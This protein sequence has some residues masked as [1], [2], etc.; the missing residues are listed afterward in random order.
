M[1]VVQLPTLHKYHSTYKS[2]SYSFIQT[3]V[4]YYKEKGVDLP[5]ISRCSGSLAISHLPYN[6]AAL[7]DVMVTVRSLRSPYVNCL[8]T[9][10]QAG[11]PSTRGSVLA[12]AS[13]SL[14]RNAVGPTKSLTPP[15][16]YGQGSLLALCLAIMM[17]VLRAFS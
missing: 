7:A 3:G 8:A 5:L 17:G 4:A 1:W 2:R 10:K 14:L 6:T 11:G 16:H 9:A 12:G 15:S 13:S